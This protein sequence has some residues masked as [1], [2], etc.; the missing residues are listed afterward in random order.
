MRLLR[1]NTRAETSLESR[2]RARLRR[3][4]AVVI[5]C[6]ALVGIADPAFAGTNATA[7]SSDSNPG[8]VGYF[9]H[10]GD[11]LRVCDVQ[12]DGYTAYVGMQYNGR[13]V[14]MLEDRSNNGRCPSETVN[15]PEGGRVRIQVCLYKNGNFRFCG[16]WRYATA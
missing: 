3:T 8:G 13:L 2:K 11:K 15:V 1:T 14:M 7:R 4:I 10:S 12:T 9:N 6:V 5:A 16:A